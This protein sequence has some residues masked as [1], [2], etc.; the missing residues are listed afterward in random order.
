LISI[1]ATER[2]ADL[3]RV[4]KTNSSRW[5]HEEF[6]EKRWFG[7][8]TGYGAFTVSESRKEDVRKYIANQ[9]EH[10]RRV[11]FQDEFLSFLRKSGLS[12]DEQHLWG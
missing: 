9:Q 8:Q 3:L 7:W 6:P 2:I 1:P 5:V 12:W 10:H 4:V 11:T